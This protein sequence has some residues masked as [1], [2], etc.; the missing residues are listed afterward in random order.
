MMRILI[1]E[2]EEHLARLVA[3]ALGKEGYAACCKPAPPLGIAGA[4]A[5]LALQPRP[6]TNQP[7][8]SRAILGGTTWPPSNSR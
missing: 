8:A 6:A 7:T 2:D 4:A 1:I 3:E 5:S